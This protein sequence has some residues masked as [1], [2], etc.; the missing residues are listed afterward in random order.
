MYKESHMTLVSYY[1]THF[2][3]FASVILASELSSK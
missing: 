2:I 3:K 1:F